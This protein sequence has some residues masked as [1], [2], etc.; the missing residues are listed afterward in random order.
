MHH[1]LK[2]GIFKTLEL[3]PK[4]IGDG[5]Y[6]HLQGIKE[7]SVSDEYTF[8]LG[9]INRFTE[10]LKSKNLSFENKR[11]IEIGSGWLPILP[12]E[13]IFKYKANEVITYDINKHYQPNKIY[14]FNQFYNQH[15]HTSLTSALPKSIKYFPQTNILDAIIPDG[16]VGA[17]VTRNVLEHINPSDLFKIHEQAYRYLDN[18]DGFIIHQIS[19]SDHRAYADKSLSLWDFL[20]YSQSEWDQIQTRFDYHNRWRLPQYTEM[21]KAC[22]YEILFLS[23]KPA[24]NGQ[25]IPSEIHPDFLK[26]SQ[27]ELTAGNVIVIL[28]PKLN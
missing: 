24:R 20:K 7:K 4:K 2:T 22:G 17:M 23:Y 16:S 28:K 10:I 5:L 15:H 1:K 13:L 9:T 18:K 27:D 12:Y 19:P 14:R 11:V 6:H 21:F 25:Q 8:Q 26:Y 3:L